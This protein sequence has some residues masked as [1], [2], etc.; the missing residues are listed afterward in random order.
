MFR[1][2]ICH[3]THAIPLAVSGFAV[4]GRVVARCQHRQELW[5]DRHP[6]SRRNGHFT[7]EIPA[8]FN[9]FQRRFI[10]S[11]GIFTW[12]VQ[13]ILMVFGDISPYFTIFHHIS[14]YFTIFHH[15]SPVHA[16]S[17]CLLK[18]QLDQFEK[19]LR[20]ALAQKRTGE[21]GNGADGSGW[22]PIQWF[23]LK[24]WYTLVGKQW[25]RI[26]NIINVSKHHWI[27][28]TAL[29]QRTCRSYRSSSLG[30]EILA[31]LLKP[32]LDAKQG[33]CAWKRR[34]VKI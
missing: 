2:Q 1:M 29:V 26:V 4:G 9:M 20:A 12:Y 17:P 6:G 11:H 10:Q 15:I 5:C 24:I 30:A 14:P 23:S 27:S 21:G 16:S 22:W 31:I 19:Q 8:G 13:D 18:E 32:G 7:T 3:G 25:M 33:G 34:W 28:A